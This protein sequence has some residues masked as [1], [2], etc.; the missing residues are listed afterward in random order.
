MDNRRKFLHGLA[1]ASGLPVD[2]L[3]HPGTVLQA[4]EERTGSGVLLYYQAGEHGLLWGD[5]EL[6]A[7][8]KDLEDQHQ[9]ADREVVKSRVKELGSPL[10]AEAD[11]RVLEEPPASPTPIPDGYTQRWLQ[12][13]R[14]EEVDLVRAFADRSDPDDV[15]EAALEDLDDFQEEAINVLTP[16]G[17]DE[18]V[19][20]ASAA[21]WDWDSDFAD[22]G[23]LV[24][25]AHR[26]AKLGTIV[27]GHTTSALYEQGR[28]PLY[29]HVKHNIGSQRI[30]ERNGFQVATNCL[31]FCPPEDQAD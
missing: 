5:S 8:L 14:P 24:D 30:A 2:R 16:N 12:A 10:F 23:V 4:N 6:L 13:D 21:P 15:E 9:T 3:D 26:L 18:L 19:A 17:S 31:F 20:Y 22:I 11:M 29:R 1:K 28:L 25:P 7:Q 27:V